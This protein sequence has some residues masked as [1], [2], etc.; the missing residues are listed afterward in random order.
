M[1]LHPHFQQ[2]ELF[3]FVR[4]ER[5]RA[6]RLLPDRLA[7]TARSAT[8][9]PE[10]TVDIE[11]PVIVEIAQRPRRPSGGGLREVG[12]AARADADPLV[13]QSRATTW[14][15]CAPSSSDPLTDAEMARHRAESTATAASIKGQVFL[16]KD[17][18]TWEDL[19]DLNGEITQ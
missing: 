4:G 17:G 11:D 10:D 13:D 9:R 14:P 5:H 3:E 6:G 7:R 18:Q 15:T 19:W 12:G 8:A 2:P 1:E 16:W